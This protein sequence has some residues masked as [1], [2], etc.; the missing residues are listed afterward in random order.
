MQEQRLGHQTKGQTEQGLPST[1]LQNQR[2]ALEQKWG[3]KLLDSLFDDTIVLA[4]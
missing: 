2:I 4:F 1:K 3:A